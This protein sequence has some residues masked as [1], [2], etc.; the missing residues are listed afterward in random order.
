MKTALPFLIALLSFFSFGCSS[1]DSGESS[2]GGD[3]GDGRYHPP[4]SGVHISEEAACTALTE[5]ATDKALGFSGC[6]I[7][8][9]LCPGFLRAQF[10]TACME[11]DEGSVNGCLDYYG[12]AAACDTLKKA[13]DACAVTPYPGTEPGG[14]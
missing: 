11:Y 8:T 1:S 9:P 10:A 14:C 7:T 5:F 13:V 2:S 4:A 12:D 6:S 3:G